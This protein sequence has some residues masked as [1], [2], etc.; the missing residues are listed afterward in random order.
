MQ[1]FS[2]IDPLELAGFLRGL[3]YNYRGP[4]S[5][6]TFLPEVSRSAMEVEFT[7]GTRVT[8]EVG[9]YRSFDA[10][11]GIS[12]RPGFEKIRYAIP[13]LA[14]KMILSEEDRLR[15]EVS[16]FFRDSNLPREIIDQIFDDAANLA[17]KILARWEYARGQ[18]LR[19]G[20][21]AFLSTETGMVGEVDYTDAGRNIQT[22]TASPLWSTAATATP[23]AD[24][25]AWIELWRDNNDNEDPGVILTSR[26]VVNSLA[27]TTDMK[28]AVFPTGATPTSAIVNPQQIEGYLA[29]WGIPPM[30]QYETKVMVNG[31]STRVIPDNLLIM[32]PRPNVTEFGETTIG[33][34]TDGLDLAEQVGQPTA[35]GVGLTGLTMKTFDPNHIWT[36]VSAMGIPVCKD[37]GKILVAT[38]LS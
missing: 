37:P 25:R 31:V 28:N 29:S 6:E 21:V 27:L 24:L 3:S 22:A 23:L 5:L 20:K 30:V 32:L 13:P 4:G 35:V 18:V 2:A 11:A 34:T 17:K 8:P 26:R 33:L 19:T 1:V 7:G 14:E 38:V 15:L 16:R 36:K 10:E 9:R 12:G